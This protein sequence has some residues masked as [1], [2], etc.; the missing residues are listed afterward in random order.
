MSRF[1][2]TA[3]QQVSIKHTRRGKVYY[4]VTTSKSAKSRKRYSIESGHSLEEKELSA[5]PW[6]TKARE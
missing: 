4:A 6:N 3:A 1:R 5:S 2:C